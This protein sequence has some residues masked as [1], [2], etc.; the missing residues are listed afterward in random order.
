[1]LAAVEAPNAVSAAARL[2][3]LCDARLLSV[4]LS[5]LVAQHLV[6]RIC[7]DC[8]ETYFASAEEISELRRPDENPA[9]A[10]SPGVAAAIPA[11]DPGTA[12]GRRS[13]R[14]SR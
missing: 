3:E 1:M 12:A 9:G 13:S 11:A 14:P 8:R 7:T 10:C 4:T 2:Q 6:R 5:C